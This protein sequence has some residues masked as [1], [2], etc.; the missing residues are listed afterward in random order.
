[1]QLPDS[2]FSSKRHF[3]NKCQYTPFSETLGFADFGVGHV[4][5]ATR[6]TRN[7]MQKVPSPWIRCK[8]ELDM[9]ITKVWCMCVCHFRI[10]DANHQ[11]SGISL[12]NWTTNTPGKKCGWP[13]GK[14]LFWVLKAKLQ[15]TTRSA[16]QAECRPHI[17]DPAKPSMAANH[18]QT[19]CQ[20]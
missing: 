10:H 2:N 1:L 19:I 17:D 11:F 4:V 7:Y 16:L 12:K 6:L 3:D 13:I 15:S 14:G 18:T 8:D 5:R 9:A 20:P